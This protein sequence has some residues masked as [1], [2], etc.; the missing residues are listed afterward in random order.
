ME[1]QDLFPEPAPFTQYYKV[2]DGYRVASRIQVGNLRSVFGFTGT[3]DEQALKVK[4]SPRVFNSQ[5]ILVSGRSRN[6]NPDLTAVKKKTIL[7]QHSEIETQID[8]V[9][10][11]LQST[12]KRC[13][14]CY[15][16]FKL[17][18]NYGTWRCSYHPEPGY[19][20]HTYD[21]C[22]KRKDSASVPGCTPCDHQAAPLTPYTPWCESN[23][24]VDIPLIAAAKLKI[25][26]KAFT[27]V[28]SS[29]EMARSKA[30]V[31]RAANFVE[32][33]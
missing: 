4:P 27:A 22:G 19:S 3:L 23:S 26:R 17:S 6:S 20:I 30:V 5:G 29:T 28:I 14:F 25:P 24:S 10:Q 1:E 8:P 31:K 33:N 13:C 11:Y 16:N 2:L 21:C 12:T 18:D 9:I 32:S 7:E 15:Q